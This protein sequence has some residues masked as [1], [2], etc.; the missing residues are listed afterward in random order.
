MSLEE[1]QIA[2][3][4]NE[5]NGFAVN[6]HLSDYEFVI[7]QESQDW[8]FQFH[9]D[10]NEVVTEVEIH[11]TEGCFALVVNDDYEVINSDYSVFSYGDC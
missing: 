10:Y 4:R 5:A 1:S 2:L 3:L 8:G 6:N 11:T 7:P 9:P